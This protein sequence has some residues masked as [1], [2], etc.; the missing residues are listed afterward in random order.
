VDATRHRRINGLA[1]QR[2]YARWRLVRFAR[3]L[4]FLA[5]TEVPETVPPAQALVVS[6]CRFENSEN[7]GGSVGMS[8][9]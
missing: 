1:R 5:K 7:D 4:G 3:H 8:K 9:P 2:W 6:P